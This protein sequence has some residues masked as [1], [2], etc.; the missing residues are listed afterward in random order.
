MLGN[1][2]PKQCNVRTKQITE[3]RRDL[4]KVQIIN[5]TLLVPHIN[6]ERE[7][8]DRSESATAED[9]EEGRKAV[10][11]LHLR[12][13]RRRHSEACFLVKLQLLCVSKPGRTSERSR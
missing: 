8:I 10:A 7:E 11:L 2:E 4:P 6:V 13:V 3:Y 1:V 12:E 9:F 5:R